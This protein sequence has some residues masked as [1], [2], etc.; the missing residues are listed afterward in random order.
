MAKRKKH[1]PYSVLAAV[2]SQQWPG[3]VREHVFALPRKWRFDFAWPEKMVACEVEGGV[4]VRGRH[5]RGIGYEK[6]C[7]KYS[8]AAALGW[9]V[10]RVTPRMIRCGSAMALVEIAMSKA[11]DWAKR[12]AAVTTGAAKINRSTGG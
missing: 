9:R 10:I 1:D 6:D 12:A 11:Q 4:Y 2:M 3:M 7:E 8:T 5:T